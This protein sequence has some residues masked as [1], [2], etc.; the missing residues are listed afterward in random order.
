MMRNKLITSGVLC[1]TALCLTAKE[2][3]PQPSAEAGTLPPS[4]YIIDYYSPPQ[5]WLPARGIGQYTL[6][7]R[8][9]DLFWLKYD[10]AYTMALRIRP[11]T[12]EQL[13]KNLDVGLLDS[14]KAEEILAFSPEREKEKGNRQVQITGL[15]VPADDV[16]EFS[17]KMKSTKAN[18]EVIVSASG[19]G[20]IETLKNEDKET[21]CLDGFKSYKIKIQPRQNRFITGFT[22]Q[23][24]ES[25]KYD[26]EEEYV[27]IDFH[28][29]RNA[30]RARFTD[31][32]QRQWI[33]KEAFFGRK[34]PLT[35]KDGIADINAFLD[36]KP[37]GVKV[38]DL[39]ITGYEL[40]KRDTEN[41]LGPKGAAET[42]GGFKVETVKETLNGQTVDALR[43]TLTK[44][45]RC[46]LKFPVE[47]DATEYNTMTMY[48]K[49]DLPEG[50]PPFKMF[51]DTYSEIYGNNC[52]NMN[53]FFDV[54]SAG[55]HSQK[56]DHAEWN[57]YGV[58]Q[59]HSMHN[60]Q[61]DAK[62][63]GGWFAIAQDLR[64]GDLP[65]NKTTTL[66]KISHWIFYYANA[67][68]P[69]GKQIV[70]T[71]A[72]PR[73]ASGLMQAGGMMEKY[74]EFLA[75][76]EKNRLTDYSDSS[77]YLGAPEKNRLAKPL[78]FIK[79]HIPQGEIIFPHGWSQGYKGSFRQIPQRAIDY[80]QDLL[81]NKYGLVY[82]VPVL[83]RPSKADNVKIFLGGSEYSKVNPEQF[84]KDKEALKGTS[85][86][87]IRSHGKNIYIY[88][89]QFNRTG[90]LRGVANGLYQFIE[91][92]TDEIMALSMS[93]HGG[94]YARE[95]YEYSKDGN[96]NLV[97][98][99]GYV[100]IPPV[101]YA[102]IAASQARY[103]DRNMN[104][105]E[106]SWNYREAYGGT[107]ANA[108]GHWMAHIGSGFRKENEKW[109][110]DEYGKRIRPDCYTRHCCM[111]NVLEDAKT[112]Y[113]HN[114]AFMKHNYDTVYCEKDKAYN[115][116]FVEKLGFW[117]EDND[118]YCQCE[119]CRTP[120]RLPDGSLL[121][122]ADPDF[123]GT[124]YY[125]NGTAMIQHVNVFARRDM[126]IEAIGYFWMTNPPR[127]EISRNFFIRF[128]PYFRKN[129]FEPIYA[130]CNDNFWRAM[131][132]WSQVD[133]E[134]GLYDYFLNVLF[135]PWGTIA[136]YD[137][138][139]EADIGITVLSHEGSSNGAKD[140]VERWVTLRVIRDP[141][142]DVQQ[143]RKYFIRRTFREAAPEMEKFYFTMTN[144]IQDEFAPNHLMELEDLAWI[145]VHAFKT[146]SKVK[147]GMNVMDEMDSYLRE[148]L[149]KTKNPMA[150]LVLKDVKD[151]WEF[152]YN[153]AKGFA[154]KMK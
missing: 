22:I 138:K 100:N 37:A 78:E 124:Q 125:L 109:G 62:V 76:K 103:L 43:I 48:A 47:F 84:K 95:V 123:R 72:K 10:N 87:A 29:K 25:G 58:S 97:W 88:G 147:K 136:K 11:V 92:N 89:G 54:F 110:V 122:S 52:S 15:K 59:I 96:M 101:S 73:V 81:K 14:K 131:Y 17:F 32:P 67:K 13:Q 7:T 93:G 42:D 64:Y 141:S 66:N 146:P 28:V 118:R 18:P 102:A 99:D 26:P 36:T 129:Y 133:V 130:P 74:R 82:P 51:G 30:P 77:K 114:Y 57:Q 108:T 53:S 63:S 143:L 112:D 79:D 86:F 126:K 94:H 3:V 1:L 152:Y 107:L 83:N 33:R 148:A 80:F 20:I 8:I 5:D 35:V 45:P 46:Y 105:H 39:P 127:V 113:L 61:K 2:P 150:K 9:P 24:P 55:V 75:D 115:Y 140:I 23:V 142:A 137:V 117:L 56:W 135:R 21:A 69:E 68:I 50:L 90:D 145:G 132:R 12:K 65:N 38:I 85:G 70:V 41:K 121:P 27:F 71:I 134:Q 16:V 111:I 153:E 151:G 4:Q 106:D 40:Q 154:D 104:W 60:K 44:G 98:G 49:I 31:L 19:A 91:Y 119:K 6:N 120:I 34:E 139:A 149:K 116:R 128:C 144:F